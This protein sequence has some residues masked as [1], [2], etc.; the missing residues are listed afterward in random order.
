MVKACSLTLALLS[1]IASKSS[2]SSS[3]SRRPANT[4]G[5]LVGLEKDLVM[6][7]E[8]LTGHPSKLQVLSFIGMGGVGKTTF[9]KNLYTDPLV[10]HHFY[11]RAW[12]TV[13]Q[14]YQ[15]REVLLGVLHCVTNVSDEMYAGSNEEL[16]ERVYRSLKG[17]RYL[18][19][20]DDIWDTKAWDELKRVLPDDKNGSR[21][22][23]TS[24]LRAVAV[25]ASQDTP[26]HCLHCLSKEDSW[27]LLISKIFVGETCR[28]ELEA[29]GK[30]IAYKCQGLPLAIV[31][32]GGLLSKMNKKLDVWE[33]VSDNVAS[34]VME[35]AENCQNILALSYVYLPDHLKQCFLYMGIFPEDYEVSVKKLIWL[36]VA[37]GFIRPRFLKSLEEVA[38]DYIEDLTTRSLI[39][40]KRTGSD[41]SIKTCYI[42]DMMRE[43]CLRESKK[44]NF[45]QVI[46]AHGQLPVLNPP[47]PHF[48]SSDTAARRVSPKHQ[49]NTRRLSFHSSI[50]SL[51]TSVPYTRSFMCFEKLSPSYPQRYFGMNVK[52]LKVLDLMSIHLA[53]IPPDIMRLTLLKFLGLTIKYLRDINS[54]FR[55]CCL[56]TI[57][58]DC[59]WDGYL[60][61]EFW[62]MQELRHFHL[63]R[64]CL[65]NSSTSVLEPVN[66]ELPLRV[67][68]NLRSVSTVRPI[69]CTEKNFLSMPHLKKLG[70]YETEEDYRFR[71]W[72]E[73]LVLLQELEALKYVFSNPFVSSALRPDRLPSWDTFPPKLVKLNMSGTSMPWEDMNMLS[74]LPKLEVLKLKNYAFSGS[75]WRSKEGGFR[76]LRFL[77]I[78]STNLEIWEAD[79][80]HFPQLQNLVLRHCRYLKEIPYGIS[81]APFLENIE[82]RNC[83][84]SAVMSAR[85]LQ[86]EQQSLGNEGLTIL[87][88][89]H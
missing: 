89:E 78:G 11:V 45:F 37:E 4:E 24:R 10:I 53:K 70:I 55:F 16:R 62:N 20:L 42:H 2:T 84:D 17:K 87:I 15:V 27:E 64:S 67:L 22:I 21:I 29:I 7:L 79:G 49:H 76:C 3:P 58:L 83:N 88:M 52:L 56:Q 13:S 59:E 74:M 69:S 38:E 51:K 65:S 47:E 23:L 81:E 43:L 39:L 28:P 1:F 31:V 73:K 82:V 35:E 32:V 9:A 50:H 34:L 86:E 85:L 46:N 75:V 57:V 61:R 25:H 66:A 14:H 19:A 48:P 60:P 8:R 33:E 41:G 72:F 40:V 63:K 77:L 54:L 68:N 5:K 26:P 6:M 18:I 36:W 44:Q 12:V 80:A 71:G 30:Q